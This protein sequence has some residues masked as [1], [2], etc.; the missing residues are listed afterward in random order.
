MQFIG[1]NLRNEKIGIVKNFLITIK[2]CALVDIVF[3]LGLPF[4]REL[5]ST[6]LLVSGHRDC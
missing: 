1:M 3:W 6:S 2:Y 4:K 5:L